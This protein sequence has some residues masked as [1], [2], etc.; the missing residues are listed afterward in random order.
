MSNKLAAK[1]TNQETVDHKRLDSLYERIATHIDVA[2]QKVQRS[3]DTEM[4]KA[5]W[6]IGR[7]IVEEEQY[8]QAR[9]EYGKAL[10]KTLSI[11]LQL[12]YRR[13]FGVD[14]LEQIR[15]FY[16]AYSLSNFRRTASDFNL[17]NHGESQTPEFDASLSWIHYRCLMRI[18][19]PE[20]RSFYEIE[21]I[22]NNWSGR[23]IKK[24]QHQ[25]QA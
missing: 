6:L 14:T 8:G 17:G 10:L 12:K 3:V 15:K 16:L 4:V 19:R 18:S 9:A 25:K 23:E 2:R 7:E 13:G 21:A 20:A 11:R 24:I 5:Y 1:I 22:K